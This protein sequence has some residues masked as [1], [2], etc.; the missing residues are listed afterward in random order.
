N[1]F[2]SATYERVRRHKVRGVDQRLDPDERGDS[3]EAKLCLPADQQRHQNDQR[4]SADAEEI[5]DGAE[6][7]RRRGGGG[8][9]ARGARR[10]R[11]GGGG[12]PLKQSAVTNKRQPR[13]T[14]TTPTWSRLRRRRKSSSATAAPSVRSPRAGRPRSPRSDPAEGRAA[15]RSRPDRKHTPLNSTHYL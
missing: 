1:S 15:G 6:N 2:R 11:S 14:H 4:Q 8:G 12:H 13:I 3:D 7:G 5:D 9:R 10:L